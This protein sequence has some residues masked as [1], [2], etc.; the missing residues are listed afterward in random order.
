MPQSLTRHI[1]ERRRAKNDTEILNLI[2]AEII[3]VEHRAL[4]LQD[5]EKG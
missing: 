4:C 2:F 3:V 1:T 5:Q